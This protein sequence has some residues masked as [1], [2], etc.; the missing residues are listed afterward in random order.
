MAKKSASSASASADSA[1]PG[2]SIMMPSGGSFSGIRSPRRRSRRATRSYISRAARTS[3][4]VVTIG[5][6]TR[7]GPADGGAQDGGELRLQ[8]LRLAQ[9]Q[10][11]A[12]Q[13]ERR[14]GV[15]DVRHDAGAGQRLD[16]LLAAPVEHPDRHRIAAHRLDDAAIGLGLGVLVRHRLAVHEQELGAQQ[17]DARPR[18]TARSAAVRSAVPD[19]PAAPPP[20][21]PASP[22]AGGAAWRSAAARARRR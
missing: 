12:A 21:R 22:P 15:G 19:W 8:Q 9:Q 17:A 7:T 3:A 5:S 20:R 2:V 13:A 6:I 4:T 11:D 16:V 10:P 14:I 1:A 18:P